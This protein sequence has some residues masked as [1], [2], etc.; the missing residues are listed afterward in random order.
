MQTI[1]KAM[2]WLGY[3]VFAVTGVWSFLL[4]LG[5]IRRA[6]GFFGFV[7]SLFLAPL[8]FTLAPWYAGF[9]W[10]NWF[11]LQLG[12][13]GGMTAWLLMVLGTVVQSIGTRKP[14]TQ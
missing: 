8:T 2:R 11:P 12:Y 14:V 7:L 13:G 1:G 3:S 6:L 5:I 9:A 4:D 10:H